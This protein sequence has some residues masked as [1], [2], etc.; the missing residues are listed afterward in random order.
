MNKNFWKQKKVFIPIGIVIALV[1]IIIGFMI[2]YNSSTAAVSDEKDPIVF[3]VESG[4]SSEVVLNKLAEQDLIKNSFAAKLC[5]KFNGLSDIK[6]GNF[7][8]NRSM[9]TKEIL[10]TLNDITKAKDDQIAITFKEGMWAKEVAQ[11]IEDNM[12]ISKETLL[13]LWNDD[14]YLR[15]LMGKYAFLSEDI[16]NTNYKVKLEGYLFPETYMF[17]K[18]ATVQEITETF[19]EHF[20]KIYLKYQGDIEASG[21]SVQEIIT[22]ASVVQYEAA[23]KSDMDM[24]AGVFYNRL[25]EGMMLQSSVTV[26][27]ALYDDLTSGEDCE[28]NTH[29]E[30]PYNTY[31]HEGLP[32]GPILNPGEEA[33]H[34]VLN[35]K[36]NDYL[37]FVADVYG[38]GSVHYAKTLAEHEANVDKYNLRK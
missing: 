24:I 28:V 25:Q 33:I 21:Y 19:L 9:S 36:D 31:L 7:S 34:A 4:E 15:S 6:A 23:K 11:L 5:M 37:Y 18:D 22:L 29:I 12:G 26:C 2:Y 1:C 3:V 20:N 8:L 13:N 16:L 14:D 32:I 30:S 27:Y 17:K 35:P 38:D 10:I